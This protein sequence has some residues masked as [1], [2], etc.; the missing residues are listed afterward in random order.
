MCWLLLFPWPTH[1]EQ[2]KGMH[3]NTDT[4]TRIRKPVEG[5][6]FF[7]RVHWCFLGWGRMLSGEDCVCQYLFCVIL[8]CLKHDS[9]KEIMSCTVFIWQELQP[10]FTQL[11]RKCYSLMSWGISRSIIDLIIYSV[12]SQYVSIMSTMTRVGWNNITHVVVCV[13]LIL[14][15]YSLQ[16][17]VI[18]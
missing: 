8:C 3:T 5:S 13:Q 16:Y 15:S 18:H 2:Y 17:V 4:C 6:L 7:P 9:Y 11:S 14:F 12:Y 10:A 1:G